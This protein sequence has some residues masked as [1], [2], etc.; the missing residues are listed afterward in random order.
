MASVQRRVLDVIT[1]H[2]RSQLVPIHAKSVRQDLLGYVQVGGDGCPCVFVVTAEEGGA[3]E[4]LPYREVR[5]TMQFALIGYAVSQTGKADGVMQA[6][7]DLLGHV[8]AALYAEDLSGNV[9]LIE[10]LLADARNNNKNGAIDARHS[11]PPGTDGGFAP[12]F[13]IFRLPCVAIL[14]Y[15]RNQV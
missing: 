14:H 8:M 3:T 15:R 13:G 10:A 4:H 5:E 9:V 11:A 12:P 7:E 6:R 1:N 2:L